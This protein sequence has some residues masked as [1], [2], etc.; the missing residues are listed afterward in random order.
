MPQQV[1]LEAVPNQSLTIRL[2]DHRYEITVK[3]ISIDVMSVSI[4]RDDMLLIQNQRA[5][6]SMLLLPAYLAGNAGNFAFITRD[7]E[8]PHWEKF[9]SDHLLFYYSGDEV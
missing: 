8:Y 4:A 6:P 3:M 9:T 1:N 5:M 7:D 2:G